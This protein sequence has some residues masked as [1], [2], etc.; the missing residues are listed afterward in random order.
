MCANPRCRHILTLELHHIVWVK[1]GGGNE[2]SNL[3]A[4]C[5]NCHSLHTN[6]HIPAEAIRVWKSML[7]TLN[8]TNRANL[9]TLLY[10]YKQSKDPHREY[11]RYTVDTVLRLAGLINAG[12]LE[13][14]SSQMGG[15]GI[16]GG[17]FSAIQV[18]LTESGLALVEAWIV[19]NEAQFNNIL[20]TNT[21]QNQS[22]NAKQ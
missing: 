14:G 21:Q 12:L 17:F 13:T 5:P 19:G 4:L 11:I 9:D 15:T 7:L 1:D 10:L 20:S 8:Q 2:P 3:L 18:K 22:L 6:G 16:G